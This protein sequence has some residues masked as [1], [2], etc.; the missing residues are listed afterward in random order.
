MKSSFTIPIA[1]I[2]GGLVVAGAVYFS[3]RPPSTSSGTGNPAL[4]RPVAS[5]DHI[6]GNPAA[7]VVI[8][9]YSDFD[10]T[11][12][13]GFDETLRQ[14]IA[15][16]GAGGEVAWVFREFPLS[17][18]HPNA[19]SHAR[20]A[21][22]AAQVA[23]NDAFWKFTNA[24][25]MNQPADPANYGT[26]AASVG[27]SSDAFATCVASASLAIDARINADRQNALAVGA[28]GTPYSLILVKGHAP[29]VMDGAYSYDAVKQLID[30]ALE[31]VK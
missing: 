2:L 4:V 3:L 24:L 15:N 31:T 20:A 27:I 11:Y 26:L 10:C 5:N 28:Q 25:F 18:I 23:G 30:Q 7:P 19:F 21:E 1:I 16:E 29:V 22:C 6:L 12:C 17:E 9:E 14:I 8:V 13:K